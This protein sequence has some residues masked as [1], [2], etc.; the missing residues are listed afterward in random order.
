MVG[1]A[2]LSWNRSVYRVAMHLT[3]GFDFSCGVALF[4][5]CINNMSVRL[6]VYQRQVM[7]LGW[8]MVA[9]L[10]MVDCLKGGRWSGINDHIILALTF[11]MPRFVLQPG[12]EFLTMLYLQSVT[13][14]ARVPFYSFSSISFL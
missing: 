1:L 10:S 7:V 4:V 9:L 11:M 8:F 14:K 3:A 2:V 6:P 5:G 13:V 12:G